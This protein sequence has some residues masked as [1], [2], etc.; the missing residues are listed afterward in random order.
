MS[1]RVDKIENLKIEFDEK[2]ILRLIGYK[3]NSKEIKD[4]IKLMIREE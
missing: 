1:S 3:K 4:P 2:R